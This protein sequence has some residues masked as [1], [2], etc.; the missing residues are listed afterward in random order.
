MA[1]GK[2]AVGILD[3]FEAVAEWIGGIEA[4]HVGHRL[5]LDDRDLGSG[6]P[7]TQ[8]RQIHHAESWMHLARG[9]EVIGYP[10][11]EVDAQTDEPA[12]AA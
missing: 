8:H 9:L 12:A 11:V 1:L 6:E 5:V 2:T 4:A 7:M 3:E 10:E